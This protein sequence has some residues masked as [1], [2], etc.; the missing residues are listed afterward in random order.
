MYAT[1]LSA[2]HAGTPI[3]VLVNGTCNEVRPMFED[4]NEVVLGQ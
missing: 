4:I 3:Y 1:L 2:Y